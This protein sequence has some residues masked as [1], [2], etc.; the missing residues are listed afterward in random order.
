LIDSYDDAVEAILV[1]PR[2]AGDG[3]SSQVAAYVALFPAGN[4]FAAGT[5]E[6]WTREGAAGRFYRPGSGGRMYTSTVRSVTPASDDEV[7][8]VVCTSRSVVVVDASG[9]EVSAEGGVTAGSIV[10]VRTDGVW[11]LR[12][13]TRISDDSCPN[14]RTQP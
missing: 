2:V 13:L 11:R 8:V 10:A 12:D 5:L 3:A 4:T 6:F 7:T 14:P 9:A 1:D